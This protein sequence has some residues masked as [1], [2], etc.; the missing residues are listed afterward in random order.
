M[1]ID[2]LLLEALGV[3]HPG[4][5]PWRQFASEGCG[6]WDSGRALRPSPSPTARHELLLLLL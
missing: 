2:D 4:V 3:L 5:E 1:P 6:F